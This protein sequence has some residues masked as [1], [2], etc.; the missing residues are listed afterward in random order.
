MAFR[1]L[2]KV[3]RANR[4]VTQRLFKTVRISEYAAKVGEPMV[5]STESKLSTLSLAPNGS[6][7]TSASHGSN[8]ELNCGCDLQVP[9]KLLTHL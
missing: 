3:Y 8:H 4:L 1:T 9:K 6:W 5:R 2:G 7:E